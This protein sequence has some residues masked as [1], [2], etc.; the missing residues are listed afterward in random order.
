[1]TSQKTQLKL[2]ND[3]KELPSLCE[4]IHGVLSPLG[5]GKRMRY[6]IEVVI[7]E[8]F[9]NIVAYAFV[10]CSTHTIGI[11]VNVKN[12]AV[13]IRFEDDGRAFDPL[14][15]DPPDYR[16]PLCDRHEGGLGIH[17]IRNMVDE[18]RY[19]RRGDKNILNLRKLI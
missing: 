1:M 12:D 10:D 9:A 14:S 13:E 17:M 15:M 6:Q 2:K 4:W 11:T 8:V 18:I 3:V 16:K 19:Q 5:L 7:E